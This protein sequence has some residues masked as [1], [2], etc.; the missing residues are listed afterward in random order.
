MVELKGDSQMKKRIG[1][2]VVVV[3]VAVGIYVTRPSHETAVNPAV[4]PPSSVDKPPADKPENLERLL[5]SNT[6]SEN[7]VPSADL[8]ALE[9]DLESASVEGPEGLIASREMPSAALQPENV[10]EQARLALEMGYIQESQLPEFHR[11]R[12]ELNSII[13][14]QQESE[15]SEA[16][17]EGVTP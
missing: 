8:E 2:A 1:L 11:Q 14:A 13:Q 15:M 10:P 12:E 7:V 5:P 16:V 9:R 3:C 17:E 4:A 6:T